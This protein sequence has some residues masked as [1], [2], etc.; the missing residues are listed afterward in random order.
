MSE[1]TF[2][3]TKMISKW[4]VP[5]KKWSNVLAC[6]LENE[7]GLRLKVHF[8]KRAAEVLGIDPNSWPGFFGPASGLKKMK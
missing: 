1:K 4:I 7:E 3:A 8:T 5:N 2:V 6:E